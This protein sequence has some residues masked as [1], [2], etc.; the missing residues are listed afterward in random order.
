MEQNSKK[1][2]I[3]IFI[4]LGLISLLI[5]LFMNFYVERILSKNIIKEPNLR[6]TGLFLVDDIKGVI[7]N[8]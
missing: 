1:N 3:S 5:G 4:L 8:A 6:I 7:N 2:T